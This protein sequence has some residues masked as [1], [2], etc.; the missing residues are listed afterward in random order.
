MRVRWWLLFLLS[1]AVL[2]AVGIALLSGTAQ[3]LAVFVGVPVMGLA[4]VRRL[5]DYDCRR[6]PPVP[7]GAPGGGL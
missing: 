7:P 1:G 4:L 2:I 3:A 5:G 6:E